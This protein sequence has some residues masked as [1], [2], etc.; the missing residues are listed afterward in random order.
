MV[1]ILSKASICVLYFS[2]IAS[3]CNPIDS[4]AKLF[5]SIVACIGLI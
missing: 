1:A 2:L 3:S 4:S 5:A